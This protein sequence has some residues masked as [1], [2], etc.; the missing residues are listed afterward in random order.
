MKNS[1]KL[2]ILSL[3]LI[4]WSAE[5]TFLTKLSRLFDDYAKANPQVSVHLLFNQDKYVGG[6]TA[7][8][9]AYFVNENFRPVA[10]KQI[11]ELEVLDQEG[12]LVQKQSFRVVEGKSENQLIL[13]KDLQPGKYR[14][15][16]FSEWMKNFDESFFFSK[17]FLLAGRYQLAA[18]KPA[19]IS[20]VSFF[21]E[22]GHIVSGVTNRVILKST[23]AGRVTIKSQ[24][25][26]T[27]VSTSLN[28]NGLGD[29]KFIPTA[30]IY[31]ELE[32]NNQKFP[33]IQTDQEGIA[34]QLAPSTLLQE[35]QE[36]AL[37]IPATSALRGQNLYLIVTSRNKISFTRPLQFQGEELH[38]SIPAEALRPGLSQL[39]ILDQSGIVKAERVFWKRNPEI[40]AVLE[41]GKE[42]VNTRELVTLDVWLKDESGNPISG[43][44]VISV[45]NKSLFPTSVSSSLDME[46]LLS[47]LPQ[48][49]QQFDTSELTFEEWRNHADYYLIP[50][51]WQRIP[52]K[53]ILEGK[54]GKSKFK[55]KN[56]MSLSGYGVYTETQEPLP[57][58][59]MIMIYL[60][61]H[62]MGYEVY[63]TKGGKFELPFMYDFWGSD[64]LFCTMETKGRDAKKE[65][66]IRLD[67][68]PVNSPKELALKQ[69]DSIEAY[70]DYKFKKDLMDQSFNL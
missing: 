17:E 16:A 39:T 3:C 33:I 34:I 45:I 64:K 62:M 42:S 68:H 47:E 30:G 65:F 4:S 36:V 28:A 55:Y 27:I 43:D 6:D 61:K 69:T 70:G 50:L 9:K 14:F 29:V 2:L 44:G 19:G 20:S 26:E 1:I 8:F 57:D 10:G 18:D 24:S 12:K 13:S 22:G 59:T 11:L 7:F 53:E 40:K 46:L 66:A 63:T 48:L 67:D 54:V 25:G 52:W 38:V 41:P 21:G 31:A 60:Q 37:S 32:G 58:S 51:T 35:P 5:D 56:S 15:V 23:P 49:R